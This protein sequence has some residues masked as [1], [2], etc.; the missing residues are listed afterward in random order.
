MAKKKPKLN[1]S[2]VNDALR[3]CDLK[4]AER[5]LAEEKAGA[6]RQGVI[7]RVVCR[8]TKLTRDAQREKLLR[9]RKNG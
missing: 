5:M 6:G 9:G 3:N 8:I 4:T 1:W 2:E 7:K